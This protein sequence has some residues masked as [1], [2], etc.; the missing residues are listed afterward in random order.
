M[1]VFVAAS[2]YL[3]WKLVGERLS[4]LSPMRIILWLLI[5]LAMGYLFG[6]VNAPRHKE[7]NDTRR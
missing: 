5:W 7:A 3:D 2:R 6:S 1:F 4:Y